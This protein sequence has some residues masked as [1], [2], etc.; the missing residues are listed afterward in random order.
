MDLRQPHTRR[1]LS[2]RTASPHA[3]FEVTRSAQN[4]DR[5]TGTEANMHTRHRFM[6]T[7][8]ETENVRE[9][10]PGYYW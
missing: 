6:M 2:H 8:K 3:L 10:D 9:R 7:G 1:I 5:Q 4:T